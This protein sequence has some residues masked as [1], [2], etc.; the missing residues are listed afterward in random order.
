VCQA[1]TDIRLELDQPV[2]HPFSADVL[3]R[4]DGASGI[5]DRVSLSALARPLAPHAVLRDP[6]KASIGRHGSTI[7]A[8]RSRGQRPAG[9][10]MIRSL[11]GSRPLGARRLI[12]PIEKRSWKAAGRE[13][14]EALP[15]TG[16]ESAFW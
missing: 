4:L 2:R 14:P 16:T 5:E 10:L 8:E 6:G 11:T 1:E 3:L 9:S 15:R 12:R 13:D 7:R